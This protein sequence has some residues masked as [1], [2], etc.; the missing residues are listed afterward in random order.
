LDGQSIIIF[1]GSKDTFNNLP[2]EESLYVLNLNNFEWSIP[3]ISGLVPNNR[4]FHTAN[5]I[6]VYMIISFGNNN[7]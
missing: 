1:G 4:M 2:P 5:V 7:I 6:G 3:K